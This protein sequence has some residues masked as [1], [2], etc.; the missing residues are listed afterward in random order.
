M[1]A[2]L[3][4]S[5]PSKMKR[6]RQQ[7]ASQHGAGLRED[8]QSNWIRAKKA[9]K[10]YV[11]DRLLDLAVKM[12]PD[13]AD[14]ADE[15]NEIAPPETISVPSVSQ[16]I[17]VPSVPDFDLKVTSNAE[18]KQTKFTLPDFNLS[19][20]VKADTGVAPIVKADTGVA[21]IVKADTPIVTAPIATAPMIQT[22]VTP[23]VKAGTPIVKA[24]TPIVKTGTPIARAPLV[25]PEEPRRTSDIPLG[26]LLKRKTAPVQQLGGA[27]EMSIT[28]ATLERCLGMI[29]ECIKNL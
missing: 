17:P 14:E 23:I 12:Q 16:A 11:Y 4:P 2:R 13:K 25:E 20:I 29:D 27:S 10:K 9:A 7:G 15:A 3:P 8:M 18:K 28:K 22:V 19:P 21:P 1:L 26:E 5:Y 24:G 6:G